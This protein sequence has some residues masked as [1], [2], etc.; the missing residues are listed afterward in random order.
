MNKGGQLTFLSR[1]DILDIYDGA[2]NILQN[3]GVKVPVDDVL[4]ALEAAGCL[5][6]GKIVRMPPS[7]V[8]EMVR[9]APSRFTLYGRDSTYA[10]NL[11]GRDVTFQPMIGRLNILDSKT[12]KRRRTNIEDVGNLV[13]VADA[14]PHY[15]LLHSGAIMPHI[16]GIPD[17]VSHV[18]GYVMSTLNSSK[19]IKGSCRGR[20][21]AVDCIKMASAIAG[22]ED[23]LRIKPNMFT[24][25]NVISPLEHA[26]EMLEGLMEF[27]KYG[28]PVDITSEP[29]T[30]ATSPVTLSGTLIQQTAEILSGVVIAQVLIPGTPVFMGTCGAAM[31][32]RYGTISLGGIEAAMLN[33]AH[34]QIARFCK[35]PSRGTGSNTDAKVLDF[36]AGY[37]K[38]VTLIL[39]ALAGINTLFYPGTLD[40]AETISIESLVLDHEICAICAHALKGIRVDDNAMAVDV[41]NKVGSGGIFLKERHTIDHLDREHF[42]PEMADRKKRDYWEEAGAKDLSIVAEEK[43]DKILSEHKPL[44]LDNKVKEN[45]LD[46]IREVEKR[47]F[48]DDAKIRIDELNAL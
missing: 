3:T 27:V 31:D 13:K 38:A 20:N 12:K 9:K 17:K 45:L 41:I 42:M 24:T 19:V 33:V 5:V 23:A 7:L 6:R 8:N 15:H 26:K 25:Y 21:K 14:L 10:V 48:G 28:L 37:E 22:G 39:P 1:D 47:E 35:I 4:K 43:V 18:Y 34:A 32:M 30:G 46:V 11:K 44:A 40:H 16:E 29:Q 36:Q 2:L